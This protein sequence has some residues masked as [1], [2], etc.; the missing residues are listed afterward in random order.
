M[1][2]GDIKNPPPFYDNWDDVHC[3]ECTMRSVLEYFEPNEKFSREDVNALTNKIEGK[4][5]WPYFCMKSL[6]DKGYKIKF[7]TPYGLSDILEDGF[8]NY[9]IKVQGEKDA[10]NTIKISPP[11]NDIEDACRQINKNKNLI[12]IEKIPEISDIKQML[13]E[14]Y[15]IKSM[16]DARALNK[17]EGYNGHAVLIYAMDD[18]HI[19][20][21]D[22]G[23][24]PV[25]ERKETIDFFIECA[26]TP[27]DTN[28]FMIGYKK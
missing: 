13:N 6:L 21:H 5:S 10:P 7:I 9:L 27:K 8:E 12:Q 23:L 1:I 25:P 28:W 4:C 15:L 17:R 19:Y 24:P 11:I 26:K 2:Y 3:M 18:T 16:I 14:G 22:S 20:F